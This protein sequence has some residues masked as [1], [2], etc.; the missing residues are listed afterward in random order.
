MTYR[1]VTQRALA[2]SIL[3]L[4]SLPALAQDAANPHGDFIDDYCAS[5]HNSEDWAGSLDLSFFDPAN[6]LPDAEV[7]EMVMVKFRG[8]MMPPQGNPRPSEEELNA[9]VSYLQDKIDPA[10]LASPD[11]GPRSL[12]RLNR[13]EYGNAVRDLLHL[14]V[15]IS[16][17]LPADDE[18]YGFDNIADV[19]RT[20]PALLE[21]YLSA[22]RKIAELAVG[23]TDIDS[24]S[25][26]YRVPPDQPQGQHI[27]GLPLGTRGGFLI[28]HYF[29]VDGE[30]EFRSFLVRNI[31]GYMTGLE[32]PHQFE[33][34]IDGERVFLAQV[35][36]EADNLASDMN[37]SEAADAIDDRLQVRVPVAAGHHQVA[38]TFL[39]KNASE[40][41][42]PLT[43]H[44]RDLDLQN[45]NGLPT[46]DYVNILGPYDISGSGNTASRDKI[47]TCY[48]ASAAEES[49]CAQQIL[50]DL[51]RQAY[52]RPLQEQDMALLMR[53]Y[54]AGHDSGGFESGVQ[55]ALRFILTS[56][57]FIFRSEPDPEHVAPGEVYALNDIAL[58]SRL[59]FFLW[60]SIP[61]EELLSLAEAGRL[62]EPAVLEQQLTRMLQNPK[63]NAL[64]DNFAAQWLLLRNLQSIQPGTRN[65]PNFD[66]K[67]R[68]AFR[69][70]TELFISS[71][72]AND[73]SVMDLLD[74]DYTYV[75]DRLASHYSIPNIYGSHFR[76]VDQT[77]EQRRGLLGHGSILT[78]TSYPDRTSPV[79]R[80][81]WVMENIL[82]APPP[83]PPPDVPELEEA[84][85]GSNSLSV[86]E[87]LIKHQENPACSGCHSALDPLGFA[88]ENF[89]AVGRF[90][91][92]DESGPIDASGQ[93]ANGT[94][95]NGAADLQA[96][97]SSRPDYFVNTMTE[98]LMTYAL[99][100][101]LEHYDMPL[102][103]KI[104][105]EA[106]EDDYRFSAIVRGIVNSVP[107]R[108]KRAASAEEV[109]AAR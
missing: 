33:I 105:D 30:Y 70:E 68:D 15:D 49:A 91:T 46:L 72:I 59:S 51:G 11:P 95:I 31:V 39:E 71:I 94:P 36:G 18:G 21:Q 89:D 107:F 12:H 34:S 38:V 109:A 78:V 92:R 9:F 104:T 52:R 57:E 97:L 82:G 56:P 45:M 4:L 80:G 54:Q 16:Q 96:V 79:L 20:S 28:E 50:S 67:L 69:T 48:P 83:P 75:N 32:W 106:A 74:A 13:T 66:N 22:S 73:S 100:R 7:W 23:D 35:G 99:G 60:S 64:V 98:K 17:L 6:P 101:G 76:R 41:H 10:T 88:M 2:A 5:C 19:L 87:R 24:V 43:L 40:T 63:A 55:R 93:L 47:F 90:R 37:F 58:A 53:Y 42:E 44:T 8:N 1:S 102:V 108:M 26:I 85:H 62:S 3:G 81:K 29:P 86:R 84:S 27:P 77:N 65:F 25:T 61:D 14:D 103:R